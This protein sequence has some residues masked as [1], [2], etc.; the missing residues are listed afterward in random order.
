MWLRCCG[1]GT[2]AWDRCWELRPALS[3]FPTS[4]AGAG[5]ARGGR[6]PSGDRSFPEWP[7]QAAA[8]LCAGCPDIST[9][10]V[11]IK[12]SSDFWNRNI[13]S[14]VLGREV[15][16]DFRSFRLEPAAREPAATVTGLQMTF[17]L[18][19]C[20]II[21]VIALPA[22]PIVFASLSKMLSEKWSETRLCTLTHPAALS[23]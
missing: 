5:G 19:N 14:S 10:P 1:R 20:C 15:F 2:A 8:Q 16:Y 17:Q 13:L 9:A 7:L 3:S 23:A 6:Q 22:Q 4:A 18:Q 11:E 12:P 21:E